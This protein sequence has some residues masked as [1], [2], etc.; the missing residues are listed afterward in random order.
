MHRRSNN[1]YTDANAPSREHGRV[2]VDNLA[3]SPATPQF[4]IFP[5]IVTTTTNNSR[6]NR[7]SVSTNREGSATRNRYA[8]QV[9]QI[10]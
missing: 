3:G 7:A 10:E 9:T 5:P 8:P 2:M 1:N 6:S 4:A